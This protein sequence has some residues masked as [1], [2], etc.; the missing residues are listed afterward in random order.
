MRSGRSNLGP[1]FFAAQVDENISNGLKELASMVSDLQA[2]N[3]ELGDFTPQVNLRKRHAGET[4][5]LLV[6]ASLVV[7]A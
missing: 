6:T 1:P 5:D 2:M 7:I 4:S 3:P